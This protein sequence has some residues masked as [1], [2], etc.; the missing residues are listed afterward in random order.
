M[1]KLW[2]NTIFLSAA[3]IAFLILVWVIAYFAVGNQYVL[4]SPW[5]TVGKAGELLG[6]K[7]FYVAFLGTLGRACLA[8]LI[9]FVLGV[10]FALIAYLYPTFEK[11]LRGIVAIL[12]SLPTVAVL[13]LILLGV[14]YAFAPV[15]IGILTLFPLLYTASIAALSSVDRDLIELSNVYRVPLM[16]RVKK[17]Y[18]PC[19]LPALLC[20]SVAALSF[21][22]KLTVSAEV[23]AFTYQSLGGL[24]QEANL[25]AEAETALL[26]TLIVCAVGIVLESVGL[27]LLR[28][29]EE[30]R[31]A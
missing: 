17:L 10:G 16:E 29:W 18:L 21:S 1:K 7:A 9:A 3:G 28:R 24:I 27:F 23:L 22:L 2:K 15:M 6:R 30:R 4:P 12:R 20:E 26:L 19:A 14:S 5:E 11:T 8:F 25:A 31:C 13:L